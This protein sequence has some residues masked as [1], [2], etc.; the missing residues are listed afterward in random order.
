MTR[1]PSDQAYRHAEAIVRRLREAGHEALLAGG[2]VRDLLRGEP[3]QDYDV[4]T[5]AR[6]DEVQAL[7]E[8]T[9]DVG[10]Q[11]GV[12]LVILDGRPYQVATFRTEG[13]YS[14]GRHPDAVAFSGAE[15]DARR[16]DFT[17]NGMF[18]DPVREEVLD[19]VGGRED[20][21]ARLIRAI[22]DPCERFR[23]DHLRLL[24]AVRFAARLG[25]AV[26]ER[27]RDAAREL[28]G[29]VSR[30]SAERLQEELRLILTDRDPA[31]ALR[32][33]DELGML[34][35]LFPE[36]ADCKGCE[37]PENYHPEGDVFVHTI[38][39]V[40]KLGPQPDF[41][42]AL[43]ALLHDVGKP[44]ASRLA[45]PK[46][47]PEHSRIGR[48]MAYEVCRRLRLS[49]D[50]TERV[51]WLVDRHLYFRD[52]QKMRQS[53]LK[54]LF[55]EPGFDQ[56]AELHRADSLA[57]WGNLDSYGY[58]MEVRRSTPPEEAEPPPLITG[59][60]LIAM[61]YAPGPMFARVLTAVRDAQLEGQVTSAEAARALARRL[62][63]EA[64]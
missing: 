57:S 58:V 49:N 27:T 18:W 56:L 37:Q 48:D 7:F 17:V 6:P 31:A 61:G 50:E 22:G 42:L 23:E 59:H 63:E 11:F 26:E 52:A 4:A 21:E 8:R 40:E 19:Y 45:G 28:A 39:T 35:E 30:V 53:T 62:A 32:L 47:F 64:G 46:R 5:T 12:C 38:L 9:R 44:E 16:R 20:L 36:L 1:R 55:A 14:D 43:A 2:C 3:P 25:F 51:C 24:R 29:L 10:R 34:L 13:A 54:R 41:Q 15:Q 33:M 60:D